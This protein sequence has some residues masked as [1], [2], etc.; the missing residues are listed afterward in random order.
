MP[1]RSAVG[2]VGDRMGRSLLAG[3]LCL[4]LLGGCGGWNWSSLNPF[5]WFGDSTEGPVSPADGIA[6]LPDNRVLVAE[7]LDMAVEPFPGGAILRASGLPP[8]QGFW[9]A[10]LIAENEGRAENGVLSF[11]FVVARPYTLQPA[12]TP[13]SRAVSVGLYLSDFKLSGVRQ[14]VVTGARNSRSVRR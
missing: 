12:G 11:R 7:V 5:T 4:T 1:N 2:V 6:V 10:E 3:L 14:I 13:P 9:D 8:T